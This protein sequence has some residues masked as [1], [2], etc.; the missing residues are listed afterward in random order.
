MR[1]RFFFSI[2]AVLLCG[3]LRAEDPFFEIVPTPVSGTVATPTIAVRGH[4]LPQKNYLTYRLVLSGTSQVITPPQLVLYHI[5]PDIL[6]FFTRPWGDYFYTENID[7]RSQ[8]ISGFVLEGYDETTST[9]ESVS[10]HAGVSFSASATATKW[11]RIASTDPSMDGTH[12][13]GAC[14]YAGP[15]NGTY[16]N[17]STRPHLPKWQWKD[18]ADLVSIMDEIADAGVNVLK[19]SWWGDSHQDTTSEDDKMFVV[20][21]TSDPLEQRD[22]YLRDAD[23]HVV[24]FNYW[25]AGGVTQHR[26]KNMKVA[27]TPETQTAIRQYSS[28][29]GFYFDRC[30][31]PETCDAGNPFCY[32]QEDTCDSYP[33]LAGS[34]IYEL[35]CDSI[36]KL[37]TSDQTRLCIANELMTTT[38]TCD[39]YGWSS[40]A[41][42]PCSSLEGGIYAFKGMNLGDVE[43]MIN[44]ELAAQGI[45]YV[46]DCTG[47]PDTFVIPAGFLI[48]R[49]YDQEMQY[50]CAV[51]EYCNYMFNAC[52]KKCRRWEYSAYDPK[53]PTSTPII[54]H[55]D[56]EAAYGGT[57]DTYEQTFKEALKHNIQ[58][59]PSIVDEEFKFDKEF[60]VYYKNLAKK[61]AKLVLRYRHNDNWLKLYDRNGLPRLAINILDAVHRGWEET[62]YFTEEHTQFYRALDLNPNNSESQYE[63]IVSYMNW[64][65]PDI[66]VL[67]ADGVFHPEAMTG[68]EQYRL[69]EYAYVRAFDLMATEIKNLT[70]GEN[71]A[72]VGFMLDTSPM[73]PS[74]TGDPLYNSTYV[75]T[76]TSTADDLPFMDYY[77]RWSLVSGF[78]SYYS[79]ATGQ[80]E[81]IGN[82]QKGMLH[83]IPDPTLLSGSGSLLAINPFNITSDSVERIRSQAERDEESTDN[84]SLPSPYQIGSPRP[85]YNHEGKY[86]FE[87]GQP[88][89]MFYDVALLKNGYAYLDYWK[90]TGLP[91]IATAIAGFNDE[92][93]TRP[94]PM[95]Y[96]DIDYWLL[97]TE[98]MM[99]LY[100]TA[101]MT[102]DIWNGF[103]EGY[104]W[105][106]SD[107][108]VVYRGFDPYR[109][110]QGGAF[111]PIDART[112]E[113]NYHLAQALFWQEPYS[114]SDIDGDFV[115]DTNDKCLPLPEDLPLTNTTR[116]DYQNPTAAYWAFDEI[117]NGDENAAYNA[118][119]QKWECT[120]THCGARFQLEKMGKYAQFTKPPIAGPVE[121]PIFSWSP[122]HDL[123]GI[124][125]ACDRTGFPFRDG[126]TGET[127]TGDGFTY[128]FSISQPAD[129]YITSAPLSNFALYAANETVSI[130]PQKAQ[131]SSNAESSVR[132]CWIDK[133]LFAFWGRD[134]FCTRKN[135][136]ENPDQMDTTGCDPNST[137]YN[138]RLCDPD[139]RSFSYSHG[140]DPVPLREGNEAWRT[141]NGNNNYDK[142]STDGKAR[143]WE[144]LNDFELQYE[145][146]YRAYIKD[147]DTVKYPNLGVRPIIN[148]KYEFPE[149]IV[150]YA[151]STTARG[152]ELVEPW[153]LSDNTINPQFFANETGNKYTRAFRDADKGR[154]LNYYQ[155]YRWK[156]KEVRTIELIKYLYPYPERVWEY[157]CPFC[158]P[159]SLADATQFNWWRYT[160]GKV[161]VTTHTLPQDD[162]AAIPIDGIGIMAFSPTDRYGKGSILFNMPLRPA[163]WHKIGTYSAPQYGMSML[164]GV[165]TGNRFYAIAGI[166]SSTVFGDLS[167]SGFTRQAIYSL[168]NDGMEEGNYKLQKIVDLP[169]GS[170]KAKLFV[171]NGTLFLIRGGAAITIYRLSDT[172]ILE[173]I[174]STI[175]PPAR[176]FFNVT[177]NKNVLLFGGGGTVVNDTVA[178]QNDFYLFNP[179]AEPANRWKMIAQN[180][181]ISLFKAMIVPQDDTYLLADQLVLEG[182]STKAVSVTAT[183]QVTLQNIQ[184][185]GLVNGYGDYCL[186]EEGV[187]LRGG[188]LLGSACQPF[189]HPWYKQYSIGSTVYSVAG[190]GDRFYV[191]T[192]SAIKVYDISDPNAMVLKS[193]FT[194]NKTVYDLEVVDGDI[195]YA[196]TSGGIYK[197]NTVNPDTLTSL[198]FY[199]TPYNYQYRI[200]LYNGN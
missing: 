39:K 158:A 170:G 168:E 83:Y 128:N 6:L 72:N 87:Y 23:W 74:L 90:K 163:D 191:G 181:P 46:F 108:Y 5:E 161:E 27:V 147:G 176:D 57:L 189:T 62:T 169:S 167:P 129:K 145:E 165:A 103:S 127:K 105:A 17:I 48:K 144:W 59:A 133:E 157:T 188:I 139:L 43:N 20:N 30:K 36:R 185:D 64:E 184:V 54:Q 21:D 171:L 182:T 89:A 124:P 146:T 177:V 114:L 99:R 58:V 117:I 199:S 8:T 26:S 113:E 92:N 16:E 44:T 160:E 7:V 86:V 51:D 97:E 42:Q 193:T 91:L 38:L 111:V 71:G 69:N 180:I 63:E 13:K 152:S 154:F 115:T 130:S 194:T 24:P 88:Q 80:T 94:G 66:Q 4:F 131:N 148:K 166:G 164:D 102:L 49:C 107:P 29:Q 132:Y 67:F 151:I 198:Q 15:F 73:P 47:I 82:G 77:D 18:P 183:G 34:N 109:Y 136:I 1:T 112:G 195:M 3:L 70:G 95:V 45:S 141:P 106:K 110:K 116:R 19:V 122:D 98:I 65:T 85:V 68:S 50:Q 100:H 135:H 200:Q 101:G 10:T 33:E 2:M 41:Q 53:P 96:G 138:Y 162:M 78:L 81:F 137:Y 150:R 143:Q 79:Y 61:L 178:E 25:M 31:L 142:L 186:D 37:Y 14:F 9:W 75:R 56:F 119:T 175:V 149:F 172:G 52:Q 60:P 187:A 173:E 55:K 190:K 140:T 126:I 93:M 35:A 40:S 84:L 197:L 32:G 120:G 159:A 123:D 134:G 118:T 179:Q 104:F 121:V 28:D 196:A 76:V 174:E 153:L 125:D 156:P 11:G 22:Y 12:V 155:Y 192:G